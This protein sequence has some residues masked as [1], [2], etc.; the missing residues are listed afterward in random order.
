[1]KHTKADLYAKILAELDYYYRTRKQFCYPVGY[2]DM[3][4]YAVHCA[5]N[6]NYE[7]AYDA[8]ERVRKAREGA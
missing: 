8:I 4:F 1:M 2:P 5:V 7:E 6:G 3:L